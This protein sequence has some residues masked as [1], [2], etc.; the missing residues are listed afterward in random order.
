MIEHKHT[1][2]H[3]QLPCLWPMAFVVVTSYRW[4]HIWLQMKANNLFAKRSEYFNWNVESIWWR[5]DPGLKI[6]FLIKLSALGFGKTN[7]KPLSELTSSENSAPIAR[8]MAWYFV[9]LPWEPR[10]ININRVGTGT[11]VISPSLE[12]SRSRTNAAT[13]WRRNVV[14]PTRMFTASAPWGTFL[15]KWWSYYKMKCG[16]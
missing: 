6:Y 16:K 1:Q 15:K 11:S 4:V 9:P 5:A 13:G 14:S 8:P 2:T 10:R 12:A 3:P 7:L